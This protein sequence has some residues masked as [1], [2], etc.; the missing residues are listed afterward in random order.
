MDLGKILSDYITI[1]FLKNQVI[2]QRS[3]IYRALLKNGYEK[4][5]VEILEYCNPQECLDKEDYYLKEFKPEYNI[6]SKAGSSFGRLDSE[7]TRA[8]KSASKMGSTNGKNQPNAVKIEVLDIETKITTLYPSI[9]EA[10]RALGC[11]HGPLQYCINTPN[12]RP[13][14]GRYVIKKK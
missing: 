2:K 11:R 3:I 12:S 1:G 5:K 8:R 7:E 6:C 14:K 10:A 13:F 4:F 9:R